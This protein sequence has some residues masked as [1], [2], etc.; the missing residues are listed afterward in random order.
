[1]VVRRNMTGVGKVRGRLGN[2]TEG[3]E[4]GGRGWLAVKG[5][6]VTGG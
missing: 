4:G 3:W 5:S 6:E 1:M 2:V